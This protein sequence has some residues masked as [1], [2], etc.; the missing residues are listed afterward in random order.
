M[1]GTILSLLWILG[2]CLAIKSGRAAMR[3]LTFDIVDV[4]LSGNRSLWDGRLIGGPEF[5]AVQ[6]IRVRD[7]RPGLCCYTHRL[8][9]GGRH[10]NSRKHAVKNHKKSNRQKGCRD[11]LSVKPQHLFIC[12]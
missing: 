12:G 1:A 2:E 9:S 7:H 3:W 5:V 11:Y 4:C 10:C 6:T 8:T